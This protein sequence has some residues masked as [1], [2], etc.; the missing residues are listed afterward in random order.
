[1]TGNNKTPQIVKAFEFAYNAH[2]GTC[3]KS[4]TIPYIVH[5]LDVASTLMKN[6]A[7][8]HVV[9]AGLLHDVV[10]DTDYTLDDIRERFGDK[11]AELV[12]G[13]SEPEELREGDG[14]SKTWRERKAHTI[15]FITGAGREMKLLSCGDK[16]SNIRDTIR[17]HSRLGE[18]FWKTFNASRN[19]QAWYYG[20]MVKAFAA[21]EDNITDLNAFKEFKQCVDELFGYRGQ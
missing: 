21:G 12:D 8:E 18:D 17:D 2:N 4:S 7:P 15:E 20:S 16:L 5:P 9:I 11:V 19:S 1:M 14:K 6:N 13:A 10:E 3:R